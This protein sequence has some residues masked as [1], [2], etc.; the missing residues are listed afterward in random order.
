M[1]GSPSMRPSKES[2]FGKPVIMEEQP[3]APRN[4]GI[5]THNM[6]VA[7]VAD[8]R[9]IVMSFLEAVSIK[10]KSKKRKLVSE[11]GS[12][13]D[14]ELRRVLEESKAEYETDTRATKGSSIEPAPDTLSTKQPSLLLERRCASVVQGKAILSLEGNDQ[15]PNM[16]VDDDSTSGLRTRL[17]SSRNN[18]RGAYSASR[19][20][21]SNMNKKPR[22]NLSRSSADEA[23]N[24]L[25]VG[26]EE[27]PMDELEEE[28]LPI[29]ILDDFTIYD[30]RKPNGKNGYKIAGLEHFNVEGYDLRASGKVKTETVNGDD[31][32]DRDI[33]GDGSGNSENGLEEEQFINISTIF[34]VDLTA[35]PITK[36]DVIWLRTQFAFYRLEQPSAMYATRFAMSLKQKCFDIS[37]DEFL[38]NDPEYEYDL[39]NNADEEDFSVVSSAGSKLAVAA[40]NETKGKARTNISKRKS[41]SQLRSNKTPSAHGRTAA[42]P[43]VTPLIASLFGDLLNCQL[44]VDRHEMDDAARALLINKQELARVVKEF[45]HETTWVGS[46]I[47]IVEDRTYYSAAQ[48][49]GI[50]LEIGDC[51][52]VRNDSEEPWI[53]K[54][55]YFFELGR[56][57][58]YHIRYFARGSETI[59]METAGAR[60]IF[61]L[62]NCGDAE[63]YTVMGKCPVTFIGDREEIP[64]KDY[65]YRFWYDKYLWTFEDATEHENLT[66]T[67]LVHCQQHEPCISCAREV[68]KERD[69]APSMIIHRGSDAVPSFKYRD[70]E[71]H[72]RDFV[73]LVN[74]HNI[75]GIMIP[76]PNCTDNNPYNVGQILKLHSSQMDNRTEIVAEVQLFE[77]YDDFLDKNPTISCRGNRIQKPVF[78]DHRRLVLTDNTQNFAIDSLEG[79]CRVKFISDSDDRSLEAQK[80][81]AQY[82]D[83]AD[84]FYYKDYLVPKSGSNRSYYNGTLVG[85]TLKTRL[86]PAATRKRGDKK[87]MQK[88]EVPATRRRRLARISDCGTVIVDGQ[89]I[90]VQ[91][92]RPCRI[93]EDEFQEQSEKRSEF[94]ADVKKLRALDIFS[95][96]GGLSLGLKESNVIETRYSIESMT[97]A[98]KTYR[99]NF[100]NARVY[101]D[102]ANILLSRAIDQINGKK[103]PPRKDFSG[104]PL[105]D[106]PYPED[107]DIIYCGPPCQGFSRMNIFQKADDLKNSLISTSMS[108]VDIYKPQYF[109]LEN[110][111]GMSTF[112]LGKMKVDNKWEGGIHI[113]VVKFVV[114][115][116]TAMGYQCRFG[117]VQAGHHNLPQSGQRLFIWGAKLGSNL[118]NFPKPATCF[119]YNECLKINPPPGLKG[120]YPFSYQRARV[121]Q[122]PDPAVTVR[123]AIGDLPGFEYINPHSEYPEMEDEKKK[124]LLEERWAFREAR[125][126]RRRKAKQIQRMEEKYGVKFSESDVDGYFSCTDES[127]DEKERVEEVRAFAKEFGGKAS[128]IPC[129][130]YFIQVDGHSPVSGIGYTAHDD[131]MEVLAD[132]GMR[133]GY[134]TRPQSEYQRRMRA[135]AGKTVMNH[136]VRAFNSKNIERICRVAMRPEADHRSLPELL[137]PRCLS[138]PK[139]AV[140]RNKGWIGLFGRLNY[141]GQ[142]QT[143]VTEMQPMGKQGKVIHPNQSRVL[144]V[145]ES[146]RVQGFPD[147]FEFLSTTNEVKWM[148]MQIGNAVPP[149]L[150]KALGTKLR[151]AVMLNKVKGKEKS[152]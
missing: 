148:Y 137:K 103:V 28:T 22:A 76:I 68:Q 41:K 3:N 52:Y 53:A 146:A 149:P 93:C 39:P 127:E 118:P 113:G 147:D 50:N 51:V 12:G 71:Y 99:H 6:D 1:K 34:C 133:G 42:E 84:S 92:P 79:T 60:E 111:R 2:L 121:A 112:R 72:E 145:R 21:E 23:G 65:Y 94:L 80:A 40:K 95:G 82:K 143:A 91:R 129:R 86:K 29:R 108:Y 134:W 130:P 31:G 116:L 106:M 125:R 98:A 77:R 47:G 142:F 59:L 104:E 16:N 87:A 66:E 49:D 10:S 128:I 25:I 115:C 54:I 18:A 36:E 140:S 32:A 90:V 30:L 123:D 70:Q 83:Q 4:N 26:E 9:S 114:R 74:S 102:D 107:V 7:L 17:R 62:D 63:L 33:D 11:S 67:N 5:A 89:T 138:S 152:G 119:P 88:D 97:S 45:T 48:V 109:L 58:H 105:L 100:P 14:E 96:C 20:S 139:S 110:V 44:N 78:K 43:C 69:D 73:Y 75:N 55:L 131:Q 141:E 24:I 27:P 117:L 57:M 64:S 19:K 151:D 61:L 144:S 8:N 15:L 101:N 124:R 46:P 38:E 150:A 132:G 13:S 85:S 81:L 56:C 136:V 120:H 126:L 122:A 35:D 37:D 135:R